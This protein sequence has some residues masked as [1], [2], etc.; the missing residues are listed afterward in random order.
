MESYFSRYEKKVERVEG[1]SPLTYFH[2]NGRKGIEVRRKEIPQTSQFQRTSANIDFDKNSCLTLGTMR[3]IMVHSK[4]FDNNPENRF[5]H[6][7]ANI[8]HLLKSL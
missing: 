4:D 2:H 1:V 3:I 6:S 5:V 7:V 8:S